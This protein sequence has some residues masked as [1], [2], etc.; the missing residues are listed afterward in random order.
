MSAVLVDNPVVVV[1]PVVVLALV[2]NMAV[3][4][5]PG[6]RALLVGIVSL[7]LVGLCEVG[8]GVSPESV[9]AA[10]RMR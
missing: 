3:V 9:F 4:G 7:V 6:G 1:V 2:V 8:R 10:C 5:E